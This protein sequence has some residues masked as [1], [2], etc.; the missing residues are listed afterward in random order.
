MLEC[1]S[2]LYWM[3]FACGDIHEMMLS[4]SLDVDCLAI[5]ALFIH[6]LVAFFM[7]TLAKNR[8]IS[9]ASLPKTFLWQ[10]WSTINVIVVI[11]RKNENRISVIS[12]RIDLK[13]SME[14]FH[15]KMNVIKAHQVTAKSFRLSFIDFARTMLCFSVCMSN[16]WKDCQLS[17][18]AFTPFTAPM[19]SN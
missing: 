1:L 16:K 8:S 3:R 7:H 6:L 15:A 19:K 5:Y 14:T 17:C 12:S 10:A 11:K 4:M 13:N 2:L 18:K 9:C